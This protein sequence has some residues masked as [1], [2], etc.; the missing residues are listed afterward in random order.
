[1]LLSTRNAI[2]PDERLSNIEK[3]NQAFQ[4]RI[5]IF[6]DFENHAQ[7]LKSYFDA[8]RSLAESNAPSASAEAADSLVTKLTSL[9]SLIKSNPSLPT[10]GGAPLSSFIPT[11]VTVVVG[12]LQAQAL[13]DELRRNG[14]TIERELAFEEAFIGWLADIAQND[15]DFLQAVTERESIIRP[16]VRGD[17]MPQDWAERRQSAFKARLDAVALGRAQQA[18]QE[19]RRNFVALAA[20][21][22][23]PASL[24]AL[25]SD[26]SALAALFQSSRPGAIVVS[27]PQS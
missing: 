16:Y 27:A 1:V 13:G 17:L 5:A 8:M 24:A 19:L 2:S 25:I 6:R 9:S 4:E 26:V 18:A 7:T 20:G 14:Q 11:V 12:G 21:D 22:L 3:S 23:S 15:F 10:I